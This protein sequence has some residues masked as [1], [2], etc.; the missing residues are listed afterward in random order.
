M[1]KAFSFVMTR[2]GKAYWKLGLDS[3]E[4]MKTEFKLDD[5][6]LGNLCPCEIS[7]KNGDYVEPDEWVFRFDEGKA[8]DWWRVSHEKASWAAFKKWKK[9]LYSIMDVKA[10]KAIK[11]PFEGIVPPKT[12]TVEHKRLLAECASVRDSVRDSV[13]NSVRDSVWNSVGDSVGDS[14][15]DSVRAS[16]WNSVGAQIG[17]CMKLPRKAWKYAEK[18]KTKEY[19]FQCFVTLWNAGLV[20]SFDG[21]TWRLHGGKDAKVLYSA[22]ETELEALR[23]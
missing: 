10:L 9:A 4:D 6:K 14:V 7:P 22:T 21:T 12:I 18:V 13:W 11:H 3:H 16:V 15:R 23:C 2:G 20:V 8:P 19:P 1:C 17:A 5:S